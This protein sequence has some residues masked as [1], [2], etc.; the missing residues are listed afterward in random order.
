VAKTPKT[1]ASK[2]AAA[3]DQKVMLRFLKRRHPQYAE[4]IDHWEFLEATYNGGR[5][6]FSKDAGNIFQY[7][8]E[9][10]KEFKDRLARA[11][12]FNHTREV[13]DLVQKYIFKAKVK[14]V[15]EEAPEQLKTFWKNATLS[16]L[17]IDQFMRLAS[18]KA[19][20][21]GMPWVFTDTT[22]NDTAI[23]K[24]DE[25]KTRAQVY[26]Y[27]VPP[28][29]ILDVGFD[30][31]GGVNWVLT[32]ETWRDDEN[33]ITASGTVKYLYRLWTKDEWRLFE[34]EKKGNDERVKEIGRAPNPINEIP[35]FPLPNVV[36]ENLYAAPALIADI[37]YL[38]RAIANY[39]SNLDAIIQDQT[40]SQLAMP[41][42][43][44]LPGEDD[45]KKVLE[46]GTK[47][48]FLFDGEGGVAPE[49]LSPD[50]KQ[51][52][53]IVVVINKIINEIYHS[54]GMGGERTKQDNAVG[55]DN[56]S[57][58]AKAYDFERMNSL[59]TSKA[60]SLENAENKLNRLVMLW[61]SVEL[62]KELVKYPDTFDVLG[63]ADELAMAEKLALVDAPHEARREQMRQ[64]LDKMFPRMSEE[65]RAKME[66]DIASWPPKV[67]LPVGER[68]VPPVSPSTSKAP[69]QKRQGQVT[70]DTGK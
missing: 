63:L 36:S 32:R 17:D 43:G 11:Y 64:M 53:V 45:Y 69:A 59:L 25:K 57:G 50:P 14:R 42:Q 20:I 55:I 15:E 21:L 38:D 29:D 51:A 66:S 67:N 33:P 54:I 8:K 18:T 62:D 4:L 46:M 40:F 27:I 49:Y 58:V 12:R 13:V 70:A 7:L 47:R 44:M 31:R 37:A 52:Q 30:E 5:E 56:S 2:A 34:I 24:A 6:W 39:L 48:V 61:N 65:L 26:A 22:K 10:D 1:S 60:S 19:S 28:Q 23:S 3:E 16:G 68:P 41:A 35:G 9:G